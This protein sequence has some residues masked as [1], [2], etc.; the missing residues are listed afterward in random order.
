MAPV[1]LRDVSEAQADEGSEELKTESGNP[2]TLLLSASCI[3]LPQLLLLN[4]KF[5][6][7]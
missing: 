1:V 2:T 6:S 5:C 7:Y 3:G 4:E